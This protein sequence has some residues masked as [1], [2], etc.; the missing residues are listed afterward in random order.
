LCG[1]KITC[2][3]NDACFREVRGNEGQNA[4]GWV[5]LPLLWQHVHSLQHLAVL[6]PGDSPGGGFSG[7]I[8]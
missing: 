7:G 3:R 8:P 5:I 2:R 6:R 1:E 4:Y